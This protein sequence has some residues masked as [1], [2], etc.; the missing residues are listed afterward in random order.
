M[1]QNIITV[2]TALGFSRVMGT[3]YQDSNFGMALVSHASAALIPLKGQEYT[4]TEPH[5]GFSIANGRT[6]E[7]ARA[8]AAAI[9]SECGWEKF[10]AVITGA[11]S[12]RAPANPEFQR[13]EKS[14][15]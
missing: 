9:L 3:V 12:K 15:L 1:T 2:Q 7:E 14:I 10:D 6:E 5:T 11:L 8:N 4:V 13:P